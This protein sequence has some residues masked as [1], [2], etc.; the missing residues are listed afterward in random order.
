MAKL[1]IEYSDTG[2][3]VE[4]LSNIQNL[5]KADVFVILAKKTKIKNRFVQKIIIKCKICE[6]KVNI[7]PE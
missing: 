3:Q 7:V 4:N 2:N 5:E 1:K 6:K